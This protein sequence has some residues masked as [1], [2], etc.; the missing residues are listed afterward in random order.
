VVSG[1]DEVSKTPGEIII[2]GKADSILA[3]AD[4]PSDLPGRWY[5]AH[6]RSR[7][8][9]ALATELTRRGVFN[10]LPLTRRT[11]RSAATRRL[12][13]SQVPVF[14]GYLFFNGSQD[15]RYVALRTN[16]IA[17]VL[18]V[19]DQQQLVGELRRIH[20]LLTQTDAF[21]VANQLV[22][23][24]WGRIT[25]GPLRGLEGVVTHYAGRLRL[26]M[27]VTILGQSVHTEVDADA[28]ERIDPPAD[29]G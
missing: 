4:I 7:N 10:Y 28:V 25:S 26:W 22:T 27:N 2:P 9:K 19:I 14:P 15:D 11:T 13:Y 20:F 18:D 16:R 24:D 21:E 5:V 23:G 17:K 29:R 12:S 1:A 3:P 6:T 8:E